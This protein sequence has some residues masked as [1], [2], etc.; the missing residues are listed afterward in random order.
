MLVTVLLAV[1]NGQ[2]YLRLAVQSILSQT[3]TD[4]EFLIIDDGSADDSV[5]ILA[6]FAEADSRI[7]L[8]SQENIG[9]T[10]TL[11]HGISLAQGEFLARMDADDIALPERLE[12]QVAYLRENRSCVMVGSRVMLIDPE[13]DPIR[14]TCDELAHEEIDQA[15]MAHGWPLVHPA[16]MIRTQAR[17]ETGG[18]DE[19]YR[20]NQDHDL[21]LRL[22][23]HG[24]V[25]NLSEVLLQYR[26]HPASISA[27]NKINNIDPL[28]RIVKAA[29]DRRGTKVPAKEISP[30]KVSFS[31]VDHHFNWGWAALAAGNISTAPNMRG[32]QF[33]KHR[34]RQTRGG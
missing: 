26:Q 9:L 34:S 14:E 20:T 8:V 11:N 29:H 28:G 27:I 6:E 31:E 19:L 3:F 33:Q 23:E 15:L 21:F 18:Y 17:R 1:H 13:G 12:K 5:Q 24:R 2:Q 22:A 16:V 30:V 7:R 32:V 10:R 4:F 25:A